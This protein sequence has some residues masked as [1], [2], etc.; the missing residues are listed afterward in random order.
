[1]RF[2]FNQMTKQAP[3]PSCINAEIRMLGMSNAGIGD[4]VL[5]QVGCLKGL[6]LKVWNCVPPPEGTE[7]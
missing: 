3:R 4:S 1:M 5:G 6:D 2:N 7:G